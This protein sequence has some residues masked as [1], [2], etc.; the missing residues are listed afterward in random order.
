MFDRESLKLVK[1]FI[2]KEYTLMSLHITITKLQTL[3]I[4]WQLFKYFERNK[5]V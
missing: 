2:A 5:E 4:D 3:R 1:P